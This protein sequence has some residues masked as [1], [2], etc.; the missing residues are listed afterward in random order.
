MIVK[1]IK[2]SGAYKKSP[3]KHA[4]DLVRYVLTAEKGRQADEEKLLYAGAAGFLDD[5]PLPEPLIGETVALI[6]EQSRSQKG[7]PWPRAATGFTLE[8]AGHE[9]LTFSVPRAIQKGNPDPCV[10]RGR[11]WRGA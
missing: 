7:H 2:Q 4:A 9:A 11:G 5:T 1:K 6:S 8:R 10:D 3:S